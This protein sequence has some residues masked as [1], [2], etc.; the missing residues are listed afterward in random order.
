MLSYMMLQHGPTAGM[1]ILSGNI[2]TLTLL[3]A[4]SYRIICVAGNRSAM[5]IILQISNYGWGFTCAASAR[6]AVCGG[7]QACVDV[8]HRLIP[9]A[10]SRAALFSLTFM[11][12]S[13]SILAVSVRA[14]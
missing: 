9:E 6:C 10:M 3:H 14:T 1:D 12:I 11:F 2:P 13:G 4:E 7:M 8:V 5:R